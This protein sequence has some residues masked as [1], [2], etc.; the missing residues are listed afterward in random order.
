MLL[1]IKNVLKYIRSKCAKKRCHR[2]KMSHDSCRGQLSLSLVSTR[3]TL[4]LPVDSETGWHL[5]EVGY[6][7]QV[8][9]WVCLNRSK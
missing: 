2:I 4:R 8:E 3:A 5:R 6:T 1:Y 9:E 7:G